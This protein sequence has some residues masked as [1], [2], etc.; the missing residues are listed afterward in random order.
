MMGKKRLKEYA[1]WFLF[2][3]LYLMTMSMTVVFLG[4]TPK[5]EIKTEYVYKTVKEKV[6]VECEKPDI[7]QA[8]WDTNYAITA[9]G[10]L[11]E[12]LLRRESDK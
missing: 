2:F 3:I 6:P 8:G 7:V 10:L 1:Q 5:P 9:K 4:C 12:L 11:N